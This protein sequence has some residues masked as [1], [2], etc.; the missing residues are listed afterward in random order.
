MGNPFEDADAAMQLGLAFAP[1]FQSQIPLNTP[2]AAAIQSQVEMFQA[3]LQAEAIKKA[4]RKSKKKG[5]G[6]ALGS[7]GG[8]G[9]GALLAA[10]T[11]GMSLAA[12]AALGGAAGGSAGSLFDQ[13]YG[14]AANYMFQGINAYNQ[15]GTPTKSADM[16]LPNMDLSQ[17]LTTSQYPAAGQQGAELQVRSG[18][19]SDFKA[20]TAMGVAA[21]KSG[22]NNLLEG[23]NE[24]AALAVGGALT[25]GSAAKMYADSTG[26]FEPKSA[27]SPKRPP[28]P[29]MRSTMNVVADTTPGEWRR[30]WRTDPMAAYARVSMLDA[31]GVKLSEEQVRAI[32][33]KQREKLREQGFEMEEPKSRF[34][35]FML[36]LTAALAAGM[37]IPESNGTET[38][39]PN[40]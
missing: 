38:F 20:D 8:M 33:K 24:T 32:P 1:V 22:T 36:P 10:P 37:L 2:E 13:N 21:P 3:G 11:G 26:E 23:F 40:F 16:S 4:A 31:N 15:Y 30:L 9:L 12:G 19:G 5:I 39:A 28:N 25:L 6:G 27:S 35:E 18:L 34:A 17:G 29:M 14:Q 7:L